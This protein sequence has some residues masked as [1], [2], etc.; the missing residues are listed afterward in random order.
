LITGSPDKHVKRISVENREVDK[1]LGQV[2]EFWITR[3]KITADDEKL[4]AGDYK[5][6]LKLISLI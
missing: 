3:M 1:D 5:G 4:L 6:D 2:C